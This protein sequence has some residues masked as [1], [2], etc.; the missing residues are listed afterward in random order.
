MDF[1]PKPKRS[2][3]YGSKSEEEDDAVL[4]RP[5]DPLVASVMEE[6]QARKKQKKGPQA[7]GKQIRTLSSAC[8]LPCAV[9]VMQSIRSDFPYDDLEA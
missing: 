2:T 5:Q 1:I 4:K 7:S 9:V 6:D 8:C 3:V